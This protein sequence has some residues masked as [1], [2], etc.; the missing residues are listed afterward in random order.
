MSYGELGSW[1]NLRAATCACELT[2]ILIRFLLIFVL[3]EFN[4]KRSEEEF[5]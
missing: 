5:S 2:Y 1:D 4:W 3:H